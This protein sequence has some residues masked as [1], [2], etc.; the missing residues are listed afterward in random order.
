MVHEV[1]V[2]PSLDCRAQLIP[3]PDDLHT[4]LLRLQI[5][6]LQAGTLKCDLPMR[7][8]LSLPASCL[9]NIS[10]GILV[11]RLTL[12]SCIVEELTQG[13]SSFASR[14]QDARVFHVMMAAV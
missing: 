7:L 10:A 14:Q 5:N 8:V 4:Y 3:A 6:S 13:L 9:D 12:V 11:C 1:E 2:V